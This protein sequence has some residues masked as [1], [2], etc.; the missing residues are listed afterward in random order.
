[1]RIAIRV[2]P[3][4]AT[5]LV[6][7]ACQADA[8][9]PVLDTASPATADTALEPARSTDTAT[10]PVPGPADTAA[11]GFVD[12]TWVVEASSA[13]AEGTTYRF[14][15]DGRLEIAGPDGGT[16]TAGQWR[17]LDESRLEMT[18]EGIAYNVDILEQGEARL[19]LRSHNPGEPV[20]ITLVPAATPVD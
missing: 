8:P 20:D 5:A 9:E 12:R 11:P 18:E 6:L 16:P 1:M 3:L 10:V 14:G 13:V 4:L 19:R 2:I 15:G 7:A 17:A